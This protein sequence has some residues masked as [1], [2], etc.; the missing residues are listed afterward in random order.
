[1]LPLGLIW[2]SELLLVI[3]S[4]AILHVNLTFNIIIL[5][6]DL[7]NSFIMAKPEILSRNGAIFISL[8][9]FGF[10]TVS[11]FGNMGT[12]QF[13][14]LKQH[15]C[16]FITPSNSNTFLIPKTISTFLC[17]SD[18]NGYISFC[19]CVYLLLLEWQKVCAHIVHY[20]FE[21]FVFLTQI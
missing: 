14:K 19:D 7:S 4:I 21:F 9:F 15:S 13:K 10:N 2:V 8:C 6:S 3:S 11:S 16:K 12:D 17:I 18:T 20:H 5:W 1:M